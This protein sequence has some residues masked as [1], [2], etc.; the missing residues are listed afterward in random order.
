MMDEPAAEFA[1]NNVVKPAAYFI[2]NHS[3][4][5]EHEEDKVLL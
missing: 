2:K 5:G 4:P 3:S 1:F